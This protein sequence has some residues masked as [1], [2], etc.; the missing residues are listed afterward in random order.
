[1]QPLPAA[2]ALD[3]PQVDAAPAQCLFDLVAVTR[4][5]RDP[6]AWET[7]GEAGEDRRQEVLGDGRAGTE[8]QFA[9]DRTRAEAHLILHAAVV[10]G[11][12]FGAGQQGFTGRGQLQAAA[13]ADEE[14]RLITGFE[15]TDMLADGGL[16]NEQLLGSP[17]ETE[18][19]GCGD[20]NF[21]SEIV[22][23]FRRLSAQG[24]Q[25]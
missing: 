19:P 22:H 5:H 8:A 21:K 4:H 9:L 10:A 14:L 12:P 24:H 23:N 16:G 25:P 18:R 13:A 2:E 17:G 3:H 11:Q 1:M 6:H 7:R 20:K 15:L